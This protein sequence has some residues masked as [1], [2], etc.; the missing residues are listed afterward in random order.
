MLCFLLALAWVPVTQHCELE[1]IGLI[2]NQCDSITHAE[3][4]SCVGDACNQLESGAYKPTNG[5][6][7]APSPVLMA[8]AC[9]M[10]SGIVAVIPPAVELPS[11]II[12][13]PP[14]ELRPTW[15]FVRRAAPLSRAPSSIQA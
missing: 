11:R 10:C 13:E 8:C 4:H 3:G 15:R 7:K 5:S 2:A 6:L 1:A 14:P 9:V 12:V